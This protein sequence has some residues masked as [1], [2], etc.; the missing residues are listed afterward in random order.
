M[1]IKKLGREL[2]VWW[3][4]P[5]CQ[6]MVRFEGI[7][8]YYSLFVSIYGSLSHDAPIVMGMW[9]NVAIFSRNRQGGGAVQTFAPTHRFVDALERFLGG[10]PREM[11]AGWSSNTLG[12]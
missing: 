8:R 12:S 11:L 5:S 9:G 10:G 4:G 6:S 1:L 7:Y 2:A 3:V